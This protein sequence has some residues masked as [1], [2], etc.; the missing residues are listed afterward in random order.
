M[1]NATVIKLLNAFPNSFINQC[2]E[3]I[4]H[5]KGLAYFT[6]TNCKTEMDVKCKVLEW[7]SRDAYKTE[8][9]NSRKSNAAYHEFIRDGIN[10][11]LGTDFTHDDIKHVYTKLGNCA[12][13]KLTIKFIESGYDM[14][15]VRDRGGKE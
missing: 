4:A 6:L 12:N 5:K 2:G 14:D 1:I 10:E 7:L 9:W 15:V 13:R 3:F 8:P 11:F